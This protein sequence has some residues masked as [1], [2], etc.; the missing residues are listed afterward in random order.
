MKKLVLATVIAGLTGNAMAVDVYTDDV[1]TVTLFGEVRSKFTSEEDDDSGT[2]FSMSSSKLGVTAKH[3][4]G[5]GY[6]AEGLLRFSFDLNESGNVE[7]SK[8]Y[9]T[10]GSDPVGVLTLGRQGSVHDDMFDYDVSW[11]FGGDAKNGRDI[12]GTGMIESGLV[13][14]WSNDQLTVMI[15]HST[16]E[17]ETYTLAE[18][19]RHGD[20][21]HNKHVHAKLDK[22][23]AVGASWKAD[24]GLG[25]SGSYTTTKLNKF[26]QDTDKSGKIEK[27]EL[28]N[29]DST[30]KDLKAKSAGFQIGYDVGDLSLAFAIF[31]FK[32]QADKK[33]QFDVEQNS[34]GFSASYKLPSGVNLYTVYDYYEV[35]DK[36]ENTSVTLKGQNSEKKVK[37]KVEGK[38]YLI[39]LDY[40]PHKQVVTFAE[41]AKTDIDFKYEGDASFNIPGGGTFT[42]AVKDTKQTKYSIGARVYF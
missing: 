41:V 34:Y 5:N 22:T 37:N 15:Q 10:V 13:Y 21:L 40:W 28:G 32:Y 16:A 20:V 29:L 24:Y 2:K 3:E 39:G 33:E 30:L 12:W 9:I 25:V 26:S 17:E 42:V 31:N 8:G 19:T 7:L 23:M 38:T 36:N 11:A 6:Y 4:L 18:E 14:K 27:D 35:E 1:S